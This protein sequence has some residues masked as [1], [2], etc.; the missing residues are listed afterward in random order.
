MADTKSWLPRVLIGCGCLTGIVIIGLAV[1]GYF[2]FFA[3]KDFVEAN[4][5]GFD[6]SSILE[7]AEDIANAAGE[8]GGA[9]GKVA[10]AVTV[11]EQNKVSPARLRAALQQPLTRKDLEQTQAI[12]TKLKNSDAYKQFQTSTAAIKELGDKQDE[13]TADKL[14]AMRDM[15]KGMAAFKEI[16]LEHDRL[17]KEAGGYDQHLGRLVRLGG[18]AAAAKQT[19]NDKKLDDPASDAVARAV[20]GEVA[21]VKEE[22]L[23]TEA[24]AKALREAGKDQEAQMM[25]LT[26]LRPGAIAMARMPAESFETWKSFTVEEREKAMDPRHGMDGQVP[27]LLF[28]AATPEALVVA[29]ET[30]LWK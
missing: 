24:E 30:D 28:L 10:D 19:A 25:M 20:P 3:A 21:A 8:K 5:D 29:S 1:A 26:L 17:V 13:S 15:T 27:A 14:A 11:E 9:A 22:F 18:V 6:S 12:F 4:A 2:G 7:K 23:K 16:Q